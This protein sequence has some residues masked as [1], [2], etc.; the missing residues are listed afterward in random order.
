MK[1]R[2]VRFRVAALSVSELLAMPAQVAEVRRT[3]AV[4]DDNRSIGVAA[5]N[6]GGPDKA[7]MSELLIR[8]RRDSKLAEG[9]LGLEERVAGQAEAESSLACDRARLFRGRP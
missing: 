1:G 6:S 7:S 8:R 9:L 2:S 4:A 5:W 3:P